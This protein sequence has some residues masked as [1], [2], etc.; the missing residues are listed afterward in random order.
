[1]SFI[2]TLKAIGAD[3][4]KVGNWIN[5]GLKVAEP[6]IGALDP[7]L[8]AIITEVEN[9]LGSISSSTKLTESQ[10]QQIVTAI[11]TLETIKSAPTTTPA[12]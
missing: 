12:T 6:I 1:M 11:T 8:G 2:S 3:F 10:V 5:D 9:V 4:E 7:P